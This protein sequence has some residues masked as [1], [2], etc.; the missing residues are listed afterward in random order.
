MSFILSLVVSQ[1]IH[2]KPMS[3]S[4]PR[5]NLNYKLNLSTSKVVDHEN[6]SAHGLAEQGI[7]QIAQS[8]KAIL[9]QMLTAVERKSGTINRASEMFHIK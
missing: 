6:G 9:S 2:S 3:E 4:N 7:P 5:P 8:R 1:P